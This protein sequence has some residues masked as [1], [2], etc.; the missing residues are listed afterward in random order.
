M[1]KER[2]ELS[3]ENINQQ[4]LELGRDLNRDQLVD[5]IQGISD[6]LNFTIITDRDENR[7]SSDD[8]KIK[9]GWVEEIKAVAE[10]L[11]DSEQTVIEYFE[12]GFDLGRLLEDNQLA[13]LLKGISNGLEIKI[14]NDRFSG[15]PNLVDIETEVTVVLKD[16][17]ERLR[18]KDIPEQ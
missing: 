13:D 18:D 7:L 11:K 2:I 9:N 8:F 1:A 12:K 4:G 16:L 17:A 14:V 15:K 3:K 10:T 6:G 5:L